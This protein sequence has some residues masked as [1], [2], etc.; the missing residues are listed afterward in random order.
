[1]TPDPRATEVLEF[2]FGPS[3]D[4]PSRTSERSGLWWG[5][6]EH[7]GPISERFG[8]LV[9]AAA[10]DALDDWAI[11]PEGA[12]A[13]VIVVDQFRR[14]VFRG[15]AEA[16]GDDARSLALSL[17]AQD[18]GW[19]RDLPPVPRVFLYMPMQHAEDIVVQDRAVQVFQA[20]AD[21]QPDAIKG[22]LQGFADYAHT[23]RDL[24]ARFGRFPHRNPILGRE[25]SAEETAYLNDGGATF[26]Q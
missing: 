21:E 22:V 11:T 16:F 26:G 23:H 24:I 5:G 2:W 12:L 15:R 10:A 9:E 3:W 17:R 19:D 25:P 1:M 6:R 7:D 20:L 18:E 8:A 13:L 4:D 14:N